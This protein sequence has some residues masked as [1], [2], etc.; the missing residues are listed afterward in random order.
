MLTIRLTAS[1]H[2]HPSVTGAKYRLL[3]KQ[4]GFRVRDKTQCQPR[5][6]HMQADAL[7]DLGLR[8]QGKHTRFRVYGLRFRVWVKHACFR[9]YGLDK[10]T[11]L[12][13]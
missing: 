5:M 12:R 6:R 13:V 8:V 4:H 2:R 10:H 3:I 7:H 11:C 1:C 9:V